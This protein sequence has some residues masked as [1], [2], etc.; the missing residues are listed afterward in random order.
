MERSHGLLVGRAQAHVGTSVRWYRNLARAVVEP[1]LGITLAEAHRAG[2]LHKTHKAER[3]QHALVGL[4]ARHQITNG[5]GHMV[6]H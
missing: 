4:G 3:G 6:D 1:Q 5:K 2:T